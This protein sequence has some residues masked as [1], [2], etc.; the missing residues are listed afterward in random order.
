[1]S[2]GDWFK[3]PKAW[4]KTDA[5]FPIPTV[6]LHPIAWGTLT[7]YC[8]P[9]EKNVTNKQRGST[10][11]LNMIVVLV[12]AVLLCLW[13]LQPLGALGRIMNVRARWRALQTSK[14]CDEDMKQE[15]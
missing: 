12:A 11:L 15:K 5:G 7:A 1:L 14:M 10:L 9:V 6:G 13:L 4:K 3:F 8:A 2:E